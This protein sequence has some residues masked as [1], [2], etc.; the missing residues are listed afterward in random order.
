MNQVNIKMYLLA[1]FMAYHYEKYDLN[2]L[3][4]FFYN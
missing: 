4:G 1:I 3:S 2:R